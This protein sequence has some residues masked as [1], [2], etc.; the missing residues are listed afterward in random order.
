MH[1]LFHDHQKKLLEKTKNYN[2]LV[3]VSRPKLVN[4]LLLIKTR[5]LL[6]EKTERKLCETEKN[7]KIPKKP[8][9]CS[10]RVETQNHMKPDKWLK[11]KRAKAE[12]VSNSS[13]RANRLSEP[14]FVVFL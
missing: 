3:F 12:I 2:F 5:L 1:K 4:Y 10:F 14:V 6:F 13:S 9:F 11:G 8:Q 7:L